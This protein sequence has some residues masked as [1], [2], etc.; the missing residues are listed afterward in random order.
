MRCRLYEQEMQFGYVEEGERKSAF[1]KVVLCEECK[2]KLR[3]GREKAKEMREKERAAAG[4]GGEQRRVE[5]APSPPRKS[6]E[7]PSDDDYGPARPPELDEP[8]RDGRDSHSRADTRS[9]RR[10]ASPPRRL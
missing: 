10:S 9:R 7:E 8:R 6:R 2:R 1:V 5:A 3:K 4:G